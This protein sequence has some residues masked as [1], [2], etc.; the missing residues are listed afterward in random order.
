MQDISNLV[1]QCIHIE[2]Y[3]V[4]KRFSPATTNAEQNGIIKIAV[5]G[6]F[7]TSNSYTNVSIV[8]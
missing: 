6:K 5:G 2:C 1:Y 3:V 7:H 8:E 4:Q